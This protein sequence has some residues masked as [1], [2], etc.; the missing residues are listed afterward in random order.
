MQR[1]RIT[2]WAVTGLIAIAMAA[3]GVLYLTQSAQGGGAVLD[4]F[5]RLGYPAVVPVL[6]GVAKVLGA[7]A[8][9]AGGVTARFPLLTEW[10]YAGFAFVLV[11]A[12]VSHVAAGD[13]PA[14]VA[15]PLVFL[16]L[17]AASYALRRRL[18]IDRRPGAVA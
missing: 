17:L 15:P 14:Q 18:T 8:L 6:L 2:F 7:V 1:S 12:A 13:G 3:S 10:A 16:A 4:N 11:G 5:V 9:V